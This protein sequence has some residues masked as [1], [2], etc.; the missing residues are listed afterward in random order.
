MM[1]DEL[2]P[3]EQP[4]PNAAICPTCMQMRVA[5]TDITFEMRRRLGVNARTAAIINRAHSMGAAVI[6]ACSSWDA[7]DLRPTPVERLRLYAHGIC[8]AIEAMSTGE[9][10]DL[11]SW[12]VRTL[13]DSDDLRPRGAG[14]VMTDNDHDKH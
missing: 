7:A 1:H 6:A 8:A 13:S 14:A 5:A 12:V 9:L 4:P 11:T 10:R 2:T 3:G